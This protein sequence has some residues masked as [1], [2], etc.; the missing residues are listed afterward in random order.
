VRPLTALTGLELKQLAHLAAHADRLA[1]A[2]LELNG[3]GRVHASGQRTKFMRRRAAC[4]GLLPAP[5]RRV[6][7]LCAR[8]ALP[9]RPSIGVQMTHPTR[10]RRPVIAFGKAITPQLP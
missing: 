7:A 5:Q 4:G 2:V 9:R 1:Q 8:R 10:S 6:P 3:Q